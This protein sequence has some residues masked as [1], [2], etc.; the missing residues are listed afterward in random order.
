MRFLM[1]VHAGENTKKGLPPDPKLLAAIGKLAEEQART[2]NF[3]DGPFSET[4]ALI[5]GFGI[6]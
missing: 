3:A 4:K 1:T 6:F 5:A 2:G